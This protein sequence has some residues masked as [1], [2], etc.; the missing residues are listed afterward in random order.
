MNY[1]MIV[2]L[3]INN[4]DLYSEYRNAMKPLLKK[5]SGGFRYDF[6][7][8]DVL[9]ND[10]GRPINRVFAIYFKNKSSR[11]IFFS[12]PEYLKIKQEFF[13]SSVEATTL[14]SEYER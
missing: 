11:D 4:E 1:E 8:S 9:K 7:V 2:G 13:E 3:Q 14:I 12:D 10:E 6:K 5:V